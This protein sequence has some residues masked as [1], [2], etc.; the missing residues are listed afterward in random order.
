MP[1]CAGAPGACR[2]EEFTVPNAQI[3]QA[4]R[5]LLQPPPSAQT[6]LLLG[7]RSE[8]GA[9]RARDLHPEFCLPGSS[10]CFKEWP[11]KSKT[12]LGNADSECLS[13]EL[14]AISLEVPGGC[15]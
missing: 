8:Q 1:V 2:T 5:S 10:A 6:S 3:P 7:L 12:Y 14:G 15:R 13:Q 11:E 4:V 9:D